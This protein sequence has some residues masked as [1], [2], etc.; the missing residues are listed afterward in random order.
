ML[1]RSCELT[2]TGGQDTASGAGKQARGAG[3]GNL[4]DDLVSPK[5]QTIGRGDV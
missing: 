3:V 4:G 5:Q 1:E 2:F